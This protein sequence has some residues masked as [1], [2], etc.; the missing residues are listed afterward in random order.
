MFSLITIEE[1]KPDRLEPEELSEIMYERL[2]ENYEAFYSEQ[3]MRPVRLIVLELMSFF[4]L[5]I[6]VL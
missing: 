5:G 6:L 2:N 1:E 4:V 3:S